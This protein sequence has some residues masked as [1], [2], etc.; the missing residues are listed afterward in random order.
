MNRARHYRRDKAS[1]FLFSRDSLLVVVVSWER[2][3][4]FDYIAVLNIHVS[5]H[6]FR[7]LSA[8]IT[9]YLFFVSRMKPKKNRVREFF[10]RESTISYGAHSVFQ[11]SF[12]ISSHLLHN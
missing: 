2:K 6:R 1:L 5:I 12:P 3:I 8:L 9:I 7:K 4:P 11:F 10:T